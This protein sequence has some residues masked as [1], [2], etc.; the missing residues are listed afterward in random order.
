MNQSSSI[1]TAFPFLLMVATAIIFFT[2]GFVYAIMLLFG[3]LICWY[4]SYAFLSS[5][6]Y[7]RGSKRIFLPAV[8]VPLACAGYFLLT[9]ANFKLIL[10]GFVVE[11]YQ[12]AYF[13]L[14]MGLLMALTTK[15]DTHE[16]EYAQSQEF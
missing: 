2:T 7:A 11:N 10:V 6:I 5:I 8:Q 14:V 1:A 3:G 4:A 13:S 16:I 15:P 12:F 9:K